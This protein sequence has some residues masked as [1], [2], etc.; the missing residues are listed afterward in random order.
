MKCIVGLGNPGDYYHQTRHNVGYQL[1]TQLS[2]RQ[3][4]VFKLKPR[5]KAEL[6]DYRHGGETVL[7]V[8]PTTFYNLSGEAVRAL[9]DFYKLEAS[10]ILAIHDE[11]ALP[12]GTIRARRGGSDA[13]NNG[14]K[15]ISQQIGSDYNRLRVGI[16][17]AHSPQADAADFVLSRFSQAEHDLLRGKLY[18]ICEQYLEQFLDGR[19]Q[20]D[21]SVIG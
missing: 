3:A 15:S 7:L 20:A 11:L 14:I 9:L 1:V 2:H 4:T 18:D 21:T 19:L 5:F 16:A 8:K 6:A 13:G 12:F 17:T 10:D